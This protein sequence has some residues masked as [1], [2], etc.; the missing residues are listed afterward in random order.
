MNIIV[1]F[2]SEKRDFYEKNDK[3]KKISDYLLI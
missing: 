1:A 2:G 3:Q